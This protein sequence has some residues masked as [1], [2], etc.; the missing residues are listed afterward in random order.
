MLIIFKRLILPVLIGLF[1]CLSAYHTY[2]YIYNRSLAERKHTIETQEEI[3]HAANK[4]DLEL[5]KFMDLAEDLAD[6]LSTERM[7][8]AQVLQYLKANVKNNKFVFGF[9]IGYEPYKYDGKRK[10]YAPFY[11]KPNDEVKL[12]YVDTSYDYTKKQWYRKPLT[13]G[14]AWFEPPYYG[15]VAQK[16]MAEYSVPFHYSSGPVRG[17]VYIDITL[18]G[19]DNIMKSLDIDRNGYGFVVS[20]SGMFVSHPV[21]EWVK[22]NEVVYNHMEHWEGKGIKDFIKNGNEDGYLDFFDR[23]SGSRNRLFRAEIKNSGWS[24]LVQKPIGFSSLNQ[25]ELNKNLLRMSIS[26]LFLLLSVFAFIMLRNLNNEKIY[27]RISVVLSI[28]FLLSIGQ[29]WYLNITS[30]DTSKHEEGKL[31]ILDRTLLLKFLNKIDSID[32]AQHDDIATKIPTGVFLE[33]INYKSANQIALSGFVWQVYDS[34][35]KGKI[36][37]EIFFPQTE[38]T[39]EAVE[40]RDAFRR[41]EKGKEIIGWYFRTSIRQGFNYSTYPLDKQVISIRLWHPDISKNILLVPDLNSYTLLNPSELPGLEKDFVL[42][43]W[44]LLESYFEYRFVEYNTN[45]GVREGMRDSKKPEL[46]YNVV[47][48]RQ[49]LSPFISN[50]IPL[51]VISI[52]LFTVVMTGTKTKIG[53]SDMLGFSGFGVLELSA[54]FF[55][56]IIIAHIDL[57]NKLELQSIIYL[58]Y[59]YFFIYFLILAYSVNSILFSR[60]EHLGFIHY[61]DNLYPRLIFW[62]ALLVSILIVTFV[63]FY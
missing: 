42:P 17:I 60:A 46:H 16:L 57:R 5:R 22:S 18:E 29:I 3:L 45:F 31:S 61:K 51:L 26:Y 14:K 37:E 1:F 15:V 10:L 40:F 49:F 2:T 21:N 58:D 13:D 19:L 7:D 20:R 50:I 34:A 12:T 32:H 56:V 11:I 36:P 43:G 55:F 24:I 4:F 39:A 30:G 35:M 38:P 28:V 25:K 53:K 27:W 59:F 23:L 48:R 6:N 9:G 62:P 33:H 47:I 44:D 63:L 8:S 54:A 52:L 41:T